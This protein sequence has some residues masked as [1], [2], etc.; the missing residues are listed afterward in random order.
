M[1]IA[2]ISHSPFDTLIS[3]SLTNPAV[4]RATIL[5]VEDENFVRKATA[6]ILESS[7]YAVISAADAEQALQ[8][9]AQQSRPIDLLI[10]D[11]IL[12]GM[13]G[14]D[15]A[16]E[17]LKLFPEAAVLLISGYPEK[18]PPDDSRSDLPYL[19]KPF[20]VSTLRQEIQKLVPAGPLAAA[21]IDSPAIPT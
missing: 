13:R 17:F 7:G 10:T 4:S 8:Q 12:P 15:L 20:S 19:A 5:L 14:D 21:S 3:P 16:R 11:L 9:C 1:E 18:I 2:E 6:E